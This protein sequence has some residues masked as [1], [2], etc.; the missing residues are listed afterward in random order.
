MTTGNMLDSNQEKEYE[1]E[2][3]GCDRKLVIGQK[4]HCG[5]GIIGALQWLNYMN[6]NCDKGRHSIQDP[7]YFAF[8]IHSK[9]SI[10]KQSVVCYR[11][12]EF[13]F[14]VRRLQ[15]RCFQIRKSEKLTSWNRET[16]PASEANRRLENALK[17]DKM[18]RQLKSEPI[19]LSLEDNL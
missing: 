19:A 16:L 1:D 10:S 17:S 7:I 14:P 9:S 2:K 8:L 12:A 4:C 18:P 15:N 13:D 6:W 11:A 3:D 5:V